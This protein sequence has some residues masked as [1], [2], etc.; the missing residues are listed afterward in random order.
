[1]RL[2]PAL[3]RTALALA[4]KPV[5]GPPV[6]VAVQRGWLE[7]T[8]TGAELPDGTRAQA[9]TLG[10]RPAERVST[11]ASAA[12]RTVLLLHGG[13]FQTC[14]PRTHR[15]LAAHLSAAAACD[16]WVPHYGR[17]PEHPHPAPLQDCL[18]AYDELAGSQRVAV[19]GDSA[20]GTLALL[21]ARERT[22][23]ALLLS[24]PVTDLTMARS[25]AWVGNDPLLRQAWLEQGVR[26]LLAGADPVALSPL[27]D[28]DA[29]L[30]RLPATLVHVG[31][32]ERLRP[33]GEAWAA[34]ASAA[35]ADV[36]CE[37]LPGAWHDVHVL[38]GLVEQARR[39]VTDMGLWLRARS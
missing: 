3:V 16:V 23:S 27:F 34:R 35:G 39:A 38:A 31:E 20:G 5:L 26:G 25:R 33:E 13:A 10:G 4:V 24:S 32:Q 28:D 18:A 14:S 30:A 12:G 15:A 9:V 37:L 2:P 8:A 21:L 7:A 11:P 6:P 36:R 29:V 1:M 19:F 22:P 17:A